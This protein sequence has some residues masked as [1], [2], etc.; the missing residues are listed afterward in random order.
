MHRV[1]VCVKGGVER[2]VMQH[3]AALGSMG[4]DHLPLC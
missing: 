4:Q 1:C 2:I 3:A